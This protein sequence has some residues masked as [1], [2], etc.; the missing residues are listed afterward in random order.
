MS[1]LSLTQQIFF[2]FFKVFFQKKISFHFLFVI[3]TNRSVKKIK[4]PPKT[5]MQNLEIRIKSRQK[6]D[7]HKAIWKEGVLK[8]I[9][10]NLE[11]EMEDFRTKPRVD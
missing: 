10:F 9:E 5:E 8:E 1:L 7:E 3:L 11:K 2:S 4:M 6:I